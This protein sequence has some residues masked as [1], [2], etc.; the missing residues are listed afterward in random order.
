MVKSQTK[1]PILD[2]KKWETR[3]E[4]ESSTYQVATPYPFAQFDGFLE[5]T[6]AKSAMDA[7]P[8][9]KDSGWIHYLHVNEK[10]H[11]LNKIDLIPTFLQKVIQTLN[12]KE[13]VEIL[14]QLTGIKG[15][16]GRS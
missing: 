5:E 6:A 11:G 2:L 1:S 4:E 16:K 7:F 9:V 15:L 14:S 3:F 8:A 10:K 12:S 13:F